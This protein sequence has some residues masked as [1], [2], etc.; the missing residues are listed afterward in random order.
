VNL[1]CPACHTPLPAA[2]TPVVTCPACAAEIDLSRAGTAVGRPRYVPEPDRSGRDVAGYQ[3]GARLGGGGMGTV[4]RAVAPGG[5]AVAIKFLSPALAGSPEVVARFAREVEV[6]AGL[7]HPAIVRVLGQG[8]DGGVPWFAMELVEGEDLRARLRRGGL[9][10]NE[11]AAIFERLLAAL[12]HA[13][14]RGVVHRDLKPANV[15]LAPDGAR[16]ADFGVA[17]W[18][19]EA[20]D[21]AAAT[22]LTETAAVIGTLPYMS[23][24]QRR[25]A[26]IDRRSD[27]FSLGVMLYEAVTGSVPQGAFPPPSAVNRDF[28]RA[29]DRL[30]L[31][32]LAPDPDARPASAEQ[33]RR[34]LVA[35]LAPPRRRVVAMAGGAIAAA[36]GILLGFSGL[37]LWSDRPAASNVAQVP[38]PVPAQKAALPAPPPN[39]PAQVEQHAEQK[40]PSKSKAGLD[41]GLLMW[42]Q[43]KKLSASALKR[44]A[45]RVASALARQA[46]KAKKIASKPAPSK[47]KE[48]EPELIEPLSPKEAVPGKPAPELQAPPQQAPQQQLLDHPAQNVIKS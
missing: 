31:A 30:V 13:H 19:A 41:D 45:P 2:G 39:P 12:A 38:P 7:D 34:A 20:T 33:A 40:A 47:S 23:P 24:E 6:L 21:R 35:A 5:R 4:Y 27:L 32:L 36:V 15:L 1:L 9:A 10:R 29:L 16:L 48:K 22:R 11:V 46:K 28:P 8:D 43:G 14:D 17:R 42:E 26:A 3:V 37:R 44:N 18:E 25:G